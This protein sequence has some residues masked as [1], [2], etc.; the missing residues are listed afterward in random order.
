MDAQ[1]GTG[2]HGA[3]VR[4]AGVQPTALAIDLGTTAAKAAVVGAD[5]S[6]LGSA[7]RPVATVFGSD[8]E[9]EQDPHAV[10]AAVLDAARAAVAA[11]GSEAARSVRVVCATSQ[12][13]SIVPVDAGG[14]PVGPMLTWLDRRGGAHLA[15]L[16]RRDPTAAD[17][18]AAVHGMRPGGSLGHVLH[19][20]QDRPDLHR[21]TAAY[22]EPMDFLNAGLCGRLAATA[23]T[24]M[25][26]TLTDNRDPVAVSWSDALITRAGVDASRLPPIVASPGVLG[27]LHD[28][29]ADDLGIPRGTP[30]A[31]GANDSVAA[32]VG[33]GAVAPGRATVVM[34]TTGVLTA[35]HPVRVVDI[36][37][38]I[39]TM[40]SAL[41]DRCFLMA[42]AG[43]GGKVL[44]TVLGE[45][46]PVPGGATTA[47]G[48]AAAASM[49]A[50]VGPGAGGVLFLPWLAGSLAPRPDG[51]LR[52][53]FL[54]LGLGTTKAELLRAVLEGVSMQMR[55]LL[56]DAEA[57]L[58]TGFPQVR[59]AGGGAQSEV[60]AQI[61]ADV[62]GRPVERVAEPRLANARGAGVL[63]LLAVGVLDPGAIEAGGSVGLVPSAGV[64]EPTPGV[65]ALMEDRL[66]LHRELHG[67]LAE[68]LARLARAGRRS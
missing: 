4:G 67:T 31:T 34:G 53:A 6:V 3:G 60:W 30:V 64:H 44:E 9:A 47:E 57:V 2:G 15:A 17:H 68:P 12:W 7:T 8:R 36:D 42:E 28:R 27:T 52:G 29:I 11:S 63:G 35:H 54:G 21:R 46:L 14:R 41:P 20:Q 51:R 65:G 23:C 38:F 58:G 45:L 19:L 43:L 26:F 62:L 61:L 24:A 66:A 18:W 50:S 32:A 33:T 48:F 5:G 13:A 39:A 37:R 25:P 22:L 40:P 49:A 10:W 55:W 1:V 59:F 16:G 56:D